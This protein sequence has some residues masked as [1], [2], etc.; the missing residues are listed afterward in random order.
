MYKGEHQFYK[1]TSILPTERYPSGSFLTHLFFLA[2]SHPIDQQILF[3]SECPG[4]L[5]TYLSLHCFHPGLTHYLLTTAMVGDQ[6]PLLPLNPLSRKART[7][8]FN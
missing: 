7:I 2:A 6:F 8:L 3:I 5:S 1:Q 4:N